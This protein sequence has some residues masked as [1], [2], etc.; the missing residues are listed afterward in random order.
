LLLLLRLPS[1]VQPA[2]GDQGLYAYAGQRM[3]A[4][5]VMYRDMWDQKP[6]A[7]A[8]TYALLLRV[9]PH[10]SMVAGADLVVAATVASLL[11]VL[12]R[13]RYGVNVGYGAAALFLLLGDPYLQRLSGIYVRGQCEPFMALAIITSLVLLAHPARQRRHLIGAGI[14]LALA[15]WLKYNAAAGVAAVALAGWAWGPYTLRDWRPVSRDLAWIA[16]GFGAVAAGV[17]A[18]FAAHGALYDLRL[19]TIDYNVHY[20]NETY[21]GAGNALA[22]LVTFP[23]ERARVDPLW[24]LG[25]IGALLLARQAR[26][27]RSALVVL[28]WLAAAVL[29]IA[30]NGGRSL[31][32]YF[33]QAN[34]ALALAGAAGLA[35]LAASG[36]VLRFGVAVLLLAGVWRVGADTPVWGLRM[37]SL[38]SL[39]ENVRYDLRYVRGHLDR[40]AYL[41]RFKGEKHDALE[42]ATLVRHVRETTA[43]ADPILVF[44]F[45]GGSVL[46]NSARVSASRFFWSRPV[47]IEFAAGYPGYGS[48]GLL[49]DL[50]R[51]PPALVV[52]QKEEWRSRDFFLQNP[53]LRNWLHAGYML[54]RETEMFSVWRRR[55]E[56]SEA[57]YVRRAIADMP[58]GSRGQTRTGFTQSR[59][60]E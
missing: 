45:S 24:F 59:R 8:F 2:G 27:N 26:S 12:G 30:I 44:G 29:S 53:D 57:V 3:L 36:R 38:P 35:T 1:L 18:Y 49:S 40:D 11:I 7:I 15:F 52:L 25:G 13:R 41:S 56:R 51:R 32:N 9:W 4:G 22:Y 14:A 48:A 33:V 20:S 16:L 37:A 50:Q 46:W 6:P 54:D 34:P 28:G 39:L 58:D 21:E 55:T 5:D 17:L 31:P 47:I 23:I 60:A 43:P 42:I 10:Q 19:A